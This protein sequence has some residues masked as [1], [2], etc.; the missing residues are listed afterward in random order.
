MNDLSEIL[1]CPAILIY[2]LILG[3]VFVFV[4]DI[5][6]CLLG[7]MKPTTLEKGFR[8]GK[9]PPWLTGLV[10]RY[11]IAIVVAIYPSQAYIVAGGWM[12]L[13]I[14]VNW[15]KPETDQKK[16]TDRPKALRALLLGLVSMALAVTGGLVC[17]GIVHW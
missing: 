4:L 11:V 5:A 16:E 6:I 10:E 8:K 17:A 13:K 15:G 2:A 3:T 1:L 14:A 9:V 7:D 12:T